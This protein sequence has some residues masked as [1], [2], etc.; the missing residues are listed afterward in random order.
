MI[1]YEQ[2]QQQPIRVLLMGEEGQVIL[3]HSLVDILPL[4]FSNSFL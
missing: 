3:F 2:K 1:E 4:A